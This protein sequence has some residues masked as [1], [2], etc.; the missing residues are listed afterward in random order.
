MAAVGSPAVAQETV[1]TFPTIPKTPPPKIWKDS[2]LFGTP[3]VYPGE[4]MGLQGTD[5]IKPIFYDGVDYQGKRHGS[6]WRD[7]GEHY[8]DADPK[9]ITVF[10]DSIVKGGDSLAVVTKHGAEKEEAWVKYKD[11]PKA[12]IVKAEFNYTTDE[13]PW[14]KRRWVVALAELSRG[15]NKA[16][17][18]VPDGATCY[19]FNIVDSRNCMV[20]SPLTIQDKRS[21]PRRGHA[22]PKEPGGDI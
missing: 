3:K 4:E 22:N 15:S 12:Q 5:E 2:D 14:E 17:A 7:S 19:Y 16:F 13:G 10:A 8:P 11:T 1:K 9:E 18:K 6:R 21:V 20:S